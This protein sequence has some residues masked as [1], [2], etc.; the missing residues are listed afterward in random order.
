MSQEKQRNPHPH[1][2]PEDHFDP[3]KKE[4]ERADVLEHD[5]TPS[6]DSIRNGEDESD[7]RAAQSVPATRQKQ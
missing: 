7:T 4:A 5:G 2:E 1:R 6:A 3:S